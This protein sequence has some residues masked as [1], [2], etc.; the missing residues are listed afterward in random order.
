MR[1]TVVLVAA[2]AGTRLGARVPKA[3]VP[4]AGRPM[5]LHP[6]AALHDLPWVTRIALVVEPSW[7]ARARAATRGFRKVRVVAGG[8]R[9]Q[10]SVAN[11][12]RAVRTGRRELVLVHDAARP[13]V[14][15]A[16]A[17]RVA[18]ATQREGAA[19]AAMP[20]PDTLKRAGG[21]GRVAATVSRAGIWQA[22]TPQ[23]I[24][25][26]LVPAW[27]AALSGPDVTDDVAPLEAAGRPVAL[28]PGS[29]RMFKVTYPGDLAVAERLVPR[30]DVRAARRPGDA[31]LRAGFG[32][33][34]HRLVPGRPLVLA[35]V[36]IPFPKGLEG[37][38]DADLICHALTDALLGATGGGDIGA[39]FGVQRK[40]TR[41]LRSVVFLET[42]VREAAARGFLV[43]NA[44]VTLL[45]QAPKIGPYRARM[46]ATLARALGISADRVSVK[47]TTAKKTGE[48]GRGEAM[49]CFALVTVEAGAA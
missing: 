46:V 10:D 16:V 30:Q 13:L 28:V 39:R 21:E 6:L 18:R 9:R 43:R 40:A 1:A 26:D 27:L 45:A 42:V 25:G 41:N 35:G 31:G 11:G 4:L 36:R 24:R 14:D 23:G 8:R 49:A 44:D 7:M 12:V 19:L 29:S 38:S 22:Q 34:L 32:Y 3:W 33:D 20:A 15:P 17:E 47:A 37:H 5:F 48:I 2:G